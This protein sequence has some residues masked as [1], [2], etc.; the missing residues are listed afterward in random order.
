MPLESNPV[1]RPQGMRASEIGVICSLIQSRKFSK[2]LEVGMANG[3]SSV[4]MLRALSASSG[5]TLTSIDPYQFAPVGSIR[6]DNDDGYSGEGLRNVRQ[7]GFADVH[8]LMAEPD[9]TALPKLVERGEKFDFVFIDGYHSFDYAFLD[10]FYADLLLKVGG[11]VAFHDSSYPA[12]YKVCRFIAGNKEYRLIGPRPEP[13]YMDM[14]RKMLRRA[15][16]WLS[17]ENAVFRERRLVW[18][19][20]TAFEKLGDSQCRQRSV[21]EF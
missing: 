9:Y 14:P 15:R 21:V 19:S 2:L 12:V 10:F 17:G 6:N 1:D 7:A 3:S 16:Y 13:M 20:V 11:V 5:G 18:C 8:T 4:S